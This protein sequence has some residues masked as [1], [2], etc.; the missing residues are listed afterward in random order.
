MAYRTACV[1]VTYE[2]LCQLLRFLFMVT[3]LKFLTAIIYTWRDT[4]HLK[5]L[6]ISEAL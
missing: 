4:F 6:N 3:I 2:L 1:Q 5:F